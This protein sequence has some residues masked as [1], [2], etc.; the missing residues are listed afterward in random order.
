MHKK[1][2]YNFG[3]LKKR[4]PFVVRNFGRKSSVSWRCPQPC[5]VNHNLT[6]QLNI[7]RHS[8]C[9]LM[10]SHPQLVLNFIAIFFHSG[11]KV[12]PASPRWSLHI[13]K[14]IARI[15]LPPLYTILGI[16]T[17]S[18]SSNSWRHHMV[19]IAMLIFKEKETQNRGG[20]ASN[21]C[22]MLCVVL[23]TIK[24]IF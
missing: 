8:L 1:W 21:S 11:R 6:R 24:L 13:W 14:H 2:Y 19:T 10:L 4:F 3:R 5:P 9:I 22:V 7:T 15:H 17:H 16:T 18:H 12:I 20:F 23:I